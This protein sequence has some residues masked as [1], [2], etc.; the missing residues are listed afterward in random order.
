M[1][2]AESRNTKEE[3]DSWDS[4]AS[5]PLIFSSPS[6]FSCPSAHFSTHL[7][8]STPPSC[9][10]LLLL[11]INTQPLPP[12]SLTQHAHLLG[13]FVSPYHNYISVY[14]CPF[15]SAC[16]YVYVLINRNS[17][18]VVLVCVCYA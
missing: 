17:K 1:E 7:P 16:V 10:P 13:Y 9:C 15:V 3:E 12:P 5:L 2:Y 18:M 14:L 8:K 6:F 11:L 4:C